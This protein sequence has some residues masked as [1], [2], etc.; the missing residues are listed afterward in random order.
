[1]GTGATVLIRGE[2]GTGKELI[3]HALH[4]HSPRAGKPFVRVNCAA[5]PE[6]LVESELFGH[7]RG[8]FTG[9][10]ARRKGTLR[11]GRRRH[12]LPRR[13]RRAE[14]VHPG[15]AAPRA[16][17]ARVRAA[18]RQ[19]D[20]AG[21]RPA[22]HGHQQGPREGARGGDLP[23]GPVL[24]AQRLHR[25]ACRRSASGSRTCCSWPTTSSSGTPG[26]HGARIKRISTP[27]IDMLMSLP[28]AG[29]RPRAGEHPRA[30]RA[31][32]RRRRDPRPPPLADAADRG[33]VGHGG[34]A[35]RWP[36]RWRRSRA[37]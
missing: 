17:G 31:G 13:D 4:H 34:L 30:R 3:A 21:G 37:T 23:G 28:L 26:V 20:R 1:M 25:S 18:G 6:T 32:G 36:R 9:A 24:P 19:R 11:A 5:L 10:Q 16:A 15:Q 12:A 7:E 2:S 22:H 33:G 29:Q 27:A 8:A 14:P 35:A